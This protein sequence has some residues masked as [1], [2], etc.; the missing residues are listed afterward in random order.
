MVGAL[1][2]ALII[3]I[4]IPVMFMVLGAL[5]SFVFGWT[6]TDAAEAD[7]PGSE[8]IDTNY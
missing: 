4:G 5:V 8:L 7:H 1:I 6:L 3:T 2:I